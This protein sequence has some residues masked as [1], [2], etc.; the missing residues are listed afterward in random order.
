V[1]GGT[2]PLLVG[3]RREVR[4]VDGPKH[5]ARDI[6]SSRILGSVEWGRGP[7]G[8]AV[9]AATAHDSWTRRDYIAKTFPTL[10]A[11]KAHVEHVAHNVYAMRTDP[12]RN[13][14]PLPKTLT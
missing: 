13:E 1:C 2:T 5:H 14:R 6:P 10:R 12:C 3:W 8:G 4:S 11:A 9:W 7:R